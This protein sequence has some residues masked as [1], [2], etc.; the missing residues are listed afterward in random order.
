M[1]FDGD[2]NLWVFQDSGN[3]CIW[4]VKNGHTQGTPDVEIFGIVPTDSEP[5]GITFTPDYKYLFMSIQHPNVGNTASQTDAAGNTVDFD[6][7]TTLVISLE[8]NLGTLS[9]KDI[10]LNIK[11]KLLPNPLD[12]SKKLVIKGR[13]INN[14]KMF[15]I[16]GKKLLEKD[17]NSLS[18][19]ELNLDDLNS[20]LYLFKI[21]DAQTAKLIIK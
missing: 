15:S 13:E 12:A 7:G 20:G 3:S 17:Y 11:T 8:E 19:I 18:E 1:A 21:N 6:K 4:V 9:V 2:G 16:L 5:T 10:S 14:V